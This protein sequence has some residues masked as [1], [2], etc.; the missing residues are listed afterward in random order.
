MVTVHW[1]YKTGEAR[2]G[3]GRIRLHFPCLVD[4][5][6]I[7]LPFSRFIFLRIYKIVLRVG[8]HI[9]STLCYMS[10]LQNFIMMFRQSGCWEGG[11]LPRRWYVDMSLGG[12]LRFK[13]F[14]ITNTATLVGIAPA[15]TRGNSSPEKITVF[16]HFYASSSSTFS[17]NLCISAWRSITS[18]LNL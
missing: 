17:V 18:L 8:G 5:P 9:A 6:V 12:L 4:V 14:F 3:K 2:G 7:L 13:L 16:L 1:N 10:F 11:V 15:E